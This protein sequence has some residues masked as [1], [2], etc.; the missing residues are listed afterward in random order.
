MFF[1]LGSKGIDYVA[2]AAQTFVDVFS[3]LK[4]YPLTAS[5]GNLL[6]SSQIDKIEFAVP[7][8]TLGDIFLANINNKKRMAA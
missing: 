5:F 1:L 3:L 4:L 6:R 2:E 7:G 8:G